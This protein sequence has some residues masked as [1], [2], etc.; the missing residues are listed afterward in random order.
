MGLAGI[1]DSSFGTA[2]TEPQVFTNIDPQYLAMVRTICHPEYSTHPNSQSL[3]QAETFNRELHA[4]VAEVLRSNQ[5]LAARIK[6]LEREGSLISK[7]E[8]GSNQIEGGSLITQRRTS[9]GFLHQD[10]ADESPK[11]TFEQELETSRVYNRAGNRHSLS[12]ATSAALHN[13]ALSVFSSLSL[14]EISN[15]SLY[16]IPIYAADLTTS[17]YYVFGTGGVANAIDRPRREKLSQL[18]WSPDLR[19][20]P[21]SRRRV[22]KQFTRR[23]IS[24]PILPVHI[25]HVELDNKS[26]QFT[27][28]KLRRI[29]FSS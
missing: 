12:S 28:R 7:G 23:S 24:A 18:G 3:Q 16:A 20:L 1:K 4:L 29:F 27:V 19:S 14:S 10:S 9:Y 8:A 26:G 6:G 21:A 2:T 13:T 11:F 25:T 15:I 5:D 17:Q 22:L